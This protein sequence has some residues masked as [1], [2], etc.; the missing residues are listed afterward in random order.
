M[1]ILGMIAV[2]ISEEP[3]DNINNEK[4]SFSRAFIEPA[5]DL[6]SRPGMVS[7][8]MFIFCYKLGEAFTTT[9]SGIVMPFLI[10]GLDFS[11][12]TIGYIN[13][14]LGVLSILLGGLTAGLFSCACLYIVLY[15]YLVYY[16]PLLI[17]FLSL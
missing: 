5:K 15:F 9:T 16:K 4:K 17:L 6:L 13:K 14:M 1:M 2:V 7:L 8:L 11:L 3:Q 12:D 10:Q